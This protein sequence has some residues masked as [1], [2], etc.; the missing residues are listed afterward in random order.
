METNV[1]VIKAAPLTSC[2]LTKKSSSKPTSSKSS[3]KP[4]TTKTTSSTPK[5][6]PSPGSR[7]PPSLPIKVTSSTP[8]ACFSVASTVPKP[9]VIDVN[10]SCIVTSSSSVPPGAPSSTPPPK[11]SSSSSSSIRC[12]NETGD[13]HDPNNNSDDLSDG[14]GACTSDKKST[15]VVGDIG[16]QTLAITKNPFKVFSCDQIIVIDGYTLPDPTDYSKR[17]QAVFTFSAHMINHFYSKNPDTFQKAVYLSSL[18]PPVQTIGAPSC[19]EFGNKDTSDRARAKFYM[20]LQTE[21][22]ALQMLEAYKTFVS[23]RAGDNLKPISS[24]SYEKLFERAC[25]G[26]REGN[27]DIQAEVAIFN[28][29]KDVLPPA[30]FDQIKRKN[31]RVNPAFGYNVPGSHPDI[32]K[33]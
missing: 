19:I 18:K 7:V 2:S 31:L 16:K 4:P 11:P 23:C 33:K 9:P 25:K 3:S 10:C 32:P 14:S 21:K 12:T 15:N 30:P 24:S 27:P 29:L 20:C 1:E 26:R 13:P 5:T 6:P 22:L 8:G 17:M 28:M